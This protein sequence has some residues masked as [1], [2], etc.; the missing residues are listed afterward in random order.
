VVKRAKNYDEYSDCGIFL[1]FALIP[2]FACTVSFGGVE[3]LLARCC[4]CGV[5]AY[6]LDKAIIKQHTPSYGRAIGKMKFGKYGR[7]NMRSSQNWNI[8]K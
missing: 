6:A 5:H 1:A 2:I 7:R 8:A 4:G 3:S